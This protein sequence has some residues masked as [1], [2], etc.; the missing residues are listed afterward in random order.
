M[1]VSDTY[2]IDEEVKI[3]LL[4]VESIMTFNENSSVT[5]GSM[6]GAKW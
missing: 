4:K 3:Y 2:E 5:S 1:E 6:A